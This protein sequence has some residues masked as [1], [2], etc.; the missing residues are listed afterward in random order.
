MSGNL[1]SISVKPPFVS[2]VSCHFSV[3]LLSYLKGLSDFYGRHVLPNRT[4]SLT[5]GKETILYSNNQNNVAV[6]SKTIIRRARETVTK[7]RKGSSILVH[8]EGLDLLILL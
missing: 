3:A 8:F 2:S 7:L 5:V 6:Y 1:N 4:K